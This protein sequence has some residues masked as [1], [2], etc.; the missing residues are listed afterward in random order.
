MP[1]QLFDFQ[2]PESTAG[3]SAIDDGVI[4]GVFASHLRHDPARVRQVGPTIADRQV[5]AFALEV[6]AISAE[7]R[8][9]LSGKPGTP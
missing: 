8:P 5:G 2:A 1:R 4:G 6:R 7:S 9:G 3:W